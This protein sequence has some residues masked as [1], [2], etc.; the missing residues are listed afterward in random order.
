M[1]NMRLHEL[2]RVLANSIERCIDSLRLSFA[3]A[4]DEEAYQAKMLPGFIVRGRISL[5]LAMTIWLL[6]CSV[7]LARGIL[8]LSSI[9]NLAHYQAAIYRSI[10]LLGLILLLLRTHYPMNHA[11]L[12]RACMLALTLMM[13]G[14]AASVITYQKLAVSYETSVMMVVLMAFFLPIGLSAWDG[15]ALA[16]FNILLV[17]LIA[18]LVFDRTELIHF[19]H[20]PPMMVL[21]TSICC[22]SA[23]LRE[24][25]DRDQYLL[26]RALARQAEIDGLTGLYNRHA[27]NRLFDDALHMAQRENGLLAL[28]VVDIDHFK[29]YNDHYGH[30]AGDIA[31]AKVAGALKDSIRQPGDAVFRIGGEEF[32]LIFR[33]ITF[34]QAEVVMETLQRTVLQLDIVHEALHPDARMSISGGCAF[35]SSMDTVSNLYQR[36]DAELYLAKQAGRAR[37][38]ISCLEFGHEHVQNSV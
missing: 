32:A 17:I 36:A 34:E 4:E 21:T 15:L 31:L 23:Y 5:M 16:V 11:E 33:K 7:D 26:R 28:V 35:A 27:F 1:L 12:R 37:I 2:L 30:P 22:F 8:P 38:R 13:V 3:V 6:F 19:V 25:S 24:R 9:W 29:R 20:L 18:Y 14:S 10:V